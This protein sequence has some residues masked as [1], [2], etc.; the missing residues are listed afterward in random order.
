MIRFMFAGCNALNHIAKNLYISNL[1]PI[2]NIIVA[3]LFDITEG[4]ANN[5]G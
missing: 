4:L 2:D 5:Y 1:S 3:Q